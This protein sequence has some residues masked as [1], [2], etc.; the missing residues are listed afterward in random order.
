MTIKRQRLPSPLPN[1]TVNHPHGRASTTVVEVVGEV[2][3]EVDAD[4]AVAVAV[5]PAEAEVELRLLT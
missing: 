2:E 5:E 4:G 3:A 1:W